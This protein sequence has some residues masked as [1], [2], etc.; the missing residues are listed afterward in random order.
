[1]KHSPL[2][3]FNSTQPTSTINSA[4]VVL[5]LS[6][7]FAFLLSNSPSSTQLQHS[8]PRPSHPSISQT[9]HGAQTRTKSFSLPTPSSPPDSSPNPVPQSSTPSQFG[10]TTSSVV[11]KAIQEICRVYG[12]EGLQWERL[13]EHEGAR[14][15]GKKGFFFFFRV[16]QND[17]VF[18]G[19][20]L[21]FIFYYNMGILVTLTPKMTLFWVFRPFSRF[22]LMEGA[23]L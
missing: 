11:W 15:K 16:Q 14:R 1:M 4:I 7:I 2:I 19:G 10:T 6:L 3:Q 17:D 12:K 23:I 13:K 8:N 21:Y 18:F 5:L 20:F 9:P 22:H